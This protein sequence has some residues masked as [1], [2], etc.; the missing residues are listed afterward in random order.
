MKYFWFVGLSIGSLVLWQGCKEAGD[1]AAQTVVD[2]QN[3]LELYADSIILPN[4]EDLAQKGEALE[5]AVLELCT[6]PSA[7]T[8]SGAQ[9]AWSAAYLA[10]ATTEVHN[11]GPIKSQRLDSKIHSWPIRVNDIET[12]IAAGALSEADVKAGG[13]LV[14]GLP[15]IEYMIYGANRDLDASAFVADESRCQYL[16]SLTATLAD[17]TAALHSSWAESGDNFRRD[18]VDAGSEDSMYGKQTE[19]LDDMVNQMIHTIQ[20]IEGDKVA[21]PLGKRNNGVAQPDDVESPYGQ[22]SKS[23]ILTNLSSIRQAFLGGDSLQDN[24]VAAIIQESS[25]ELYEEVTAAITAAE[26]SLGQTTGSLSIAVQGDE[27]ALVE[28][29]FTSLK[30]LLRLFAADVAGVLGVTPTFSDNDGD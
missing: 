21:R 5:T 16:L 18:F 22:L 9:A 7:E 25:P 15:V 20:F 26:S 3:L 2:R 30:E 14:K 11:F 17:N 27:A 19:A 1:P 29:C 10:F 28:G 24:S 23:L 4:Y 12:F 13:A 8:Y 6:N